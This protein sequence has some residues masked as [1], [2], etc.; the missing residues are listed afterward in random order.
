MILITSFS[1]LNDWLNTNLLTLNCDRTKQVQFVTKLTFNSGTSVRYHNNTISNRTNLSILGK[2]MEISCT[3]KA[4]IS[5]LMPKFCKACYSVR[6]IKPIIPTETIKMVYYS[7]FHSL[8]TYGI[9]FLGNSSFSEQI[10]RIQKR[11]IRVGC[12]PGTLAGL[13]LGTGKFCHYSPNIYFLY[14]CLSRTIWI[15]I[16]QHHKFMD[17]IQGEILI[18]IALRQT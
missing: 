16:I 15:C 8:L 14:W 9:I 5:Q 3:W 4:H 13:H 17:L 2:V 7:Y 12:K 6:V 1:L 18:S 11:I 10:F